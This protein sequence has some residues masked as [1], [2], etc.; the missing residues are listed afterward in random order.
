MYICVSVTESFIALITFVIPD[1]TSDAF[2]MV[3]IPGDISFNDFQDK[4]FETYGCSNVKIKPKLTYKIGA[5]GMS[6]SLD[7]DIN[8]SMLKENNDLLKKG[9]KITIIIDSKV[10]QYLS[11]N[12]F[13]ALLDYT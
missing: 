4:V 8:F 1:G 13:L 12:K 7:D 9:T 10:W 11:L 2:K 5:C 3:L 6:H